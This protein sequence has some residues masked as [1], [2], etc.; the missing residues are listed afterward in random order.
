M[1]TLYE[2]IGGEKGVDAIVTSFQ[3]YMLSDPITS[4]FFAKTDMV[5][6]AKR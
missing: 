2:R 4:P 1:A 5:V 3:K 6:Q